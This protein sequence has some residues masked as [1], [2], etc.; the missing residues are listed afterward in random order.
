[1]RALD[2]F[3]NQTF[4]KPFEII[5]CDNGADPKVEEIICKYNE[6]AQEKVKYFGQGGGIHQV[7]SRLAYEAKGD[8]ILMIDDDESACPELLE[9]YDNLFSKHEDLAAA[10]GP[11]IMEWEDAPPEWVL[12]YVEG[13]RVSNIW[14]RYE[15][16]DKLKIGVG[17]GIWGG[18]MVFRRQ[19]FDYTGFRPDIFMGKNMGDGETG[20][21]IEIARRELKTAYVPEAYI[22]HYMDK[23]RFNLNYVRRT[24]SYVGVPFAYWRWHEAK[25]SIHQYIIELFR[26]SKTYYKIWIRYIYFQ[27]FGRKITNA[28]INA[29]FQANVGLFQIK[30]IYWLITDRYFRLNCDW[31]DFRPESCI[32]LYSDCYKQRKK[33][34]ESD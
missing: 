1:M 23:S 2:S 26:I 5:V 4:N 19:I 9:I 20:L 24:A 3:Q 8:L 18:N 33:I 11:C 22:L 31:D 13:K 28:K 25:R 15:P 30:Y 6:T 12:N 34:L 21:F 7:R 16:Y 32:R 17:I 10:G 29:E 14:G 27:I